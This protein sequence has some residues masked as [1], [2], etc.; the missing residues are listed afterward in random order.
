MIQFNS[1]ENRHK[2]WLILPLH[3]IITIAEQRKVFIAP[4]GDFRKIILSTNIA[5]S[6]ITV[7]DIVYVID[8]CLTKQMVCDPKNHCTMLQLEWAAKS[9]CDQRAGRAGRVQDG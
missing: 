4:E 1:V 9:N 6:S 8:F 2:K 7:P 5:E 3:S